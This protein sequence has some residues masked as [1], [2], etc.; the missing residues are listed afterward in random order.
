VREIAGCQPTG[1]MHLGEEDLFGRSAFGP[2]P[3]DVPLQS[4]QLAV[5]EATGEAPLQIGEQGL[6]FQSGIDQQLGLQ[7]GPDVA[8]RSARVRQFLSIIVTSLGSLP[9]KRYLRA[10]LASC[11][12]VLPPPLWQSL[13]RQG[14][15]ACA[16]ADR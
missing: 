12:C 5:R 2:P 15:G 16:L 1:M 8:K 7:F 11:R 10:V 6:R 9:S 3:F 13:A 14:D 4:P